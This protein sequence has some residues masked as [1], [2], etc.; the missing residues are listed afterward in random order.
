LPCPLRLQNTVQRQAYNGRLLRRPVERWSTSTMNILKA[1]ILIVASS[2]RRGHGELTWAFDRLAGPTNP[3]YK[4][5]S[6]RC[7]DRQMAV[8]GNNVKLDIPKRQDPGIAC[9]VQAGRV[10][11]GNTIQTIVFTPPDRYR[12]PPATTPTQTRTAI[13]PPIP[14]DEPEPQLPGLAVA[15]DY[16][17]TRIGRL[18]PDVC[19][20][21]KTRSARATSYDLYSRSAGSD[22]KLV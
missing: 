16:S 10:G 1:G 20:V 4:P 11:R 6:I 22:R 3:S 7:R 18:V 21:G 9:S 2:A 17:C 19:A 5:S 8:H 12:S 13:V 15:I 14:G